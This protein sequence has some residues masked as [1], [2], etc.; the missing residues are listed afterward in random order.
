MF[1][2][3]FSWLESCLASL[4]VF[5]ANALRYYSFMLYEHR[6]IAI[7]TNLLIKATYNNFSGV[8]TLDILLSKT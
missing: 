5:D 2:A 8:F 4:E 7:I 3:G 6:M 1:K